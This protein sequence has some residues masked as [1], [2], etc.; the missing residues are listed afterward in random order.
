VLQ[1]SGRAGSDEALHA[2]SSLLH[3]G[4][5]RSILNAVASFVK[6]GNDNVGYE[7]VVDLALQLVGE[8]RDD[9][10]RQLFP[11]ASREAP[12]QKRASRFAG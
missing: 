3:P 7:V 4:V 10:R 12:G 9:P 6:N 2:L 5:Q 11:V 8:G 1:L